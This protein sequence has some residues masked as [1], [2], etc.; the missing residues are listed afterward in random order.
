MISLPIRTGR[1]K[2][3]RRSNNARNYFHPPSASLYFT[4]PAAFS[5]TKCDSTAVSLFAGKCEQNPTPA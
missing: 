3:L 5:N 2:G 1:S 4:F